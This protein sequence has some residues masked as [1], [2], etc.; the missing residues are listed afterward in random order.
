M[1]PPG[2][3]VKVYEHFARHKVTAT[4]FRI[5]A[6]RPHLL[7]VIY[8]WNN[9]TKYTHHIELRLCLSERRIVWGVNKWMAAKRKWM[10]WLQFHQYINHSAIFETTS[11]NSMYLNVL[12]ALFPSTSIACTYN[13]ISNI[14]W[15]ANASWWWFAFIPL[16][17]A[18]LWRH[19]LHRFLFHISQT[20]LS[21]ETMAKWAFNDWIRLY[22]YYVINA[23]NIHEIYNYM[24]SIGISAHSESNFFGLAYVWNH[25][26]LI[27]WEAHKYLRLYNNFYRAT[28]RHIVFMVFTEWIAWLGN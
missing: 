2:V 10:N 8:S 23:Y 28:S 17:I 24:S 25:F 12:D 16:V 4:T 1:N 13:V 9:L 11:T 27:E 18:P 20:E 21:R 19:W 5:S 3:Y 26:L 15:K 6:T 14:N 7:N 22:V